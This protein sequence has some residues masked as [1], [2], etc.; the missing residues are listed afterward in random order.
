VKSIIQTLAE[1]KKQIAM[2]D[3]AKSFMRSLVGEL[4]GNIQE[5]FVALGAKVDV[6]TSSRPEL[7]ARVAELQTAVGEVQ[8][9]ALTHQPHV[10]IDIPPA[11]ATVPAGA[12]KAA[13]TNL[14]TAHLGACPGKFGHGVAANC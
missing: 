6:L 5:S 3:E 11:P 4:S 14:G 7:E 13:A 10:A 2:D 8:H 1:K 9:S 12:G